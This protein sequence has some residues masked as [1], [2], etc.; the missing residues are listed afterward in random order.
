MAYLCAYAEKLLHP[1]SARHQKRENKETTKQK[2]G[3]SED[4]VRMIVREGSPYCSVNSQGD[5]HVN[6]IMFA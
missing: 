4:T 6:D 5:V 1:H 3:S 2:P